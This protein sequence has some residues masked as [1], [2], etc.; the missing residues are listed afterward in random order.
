MGAGG[1]CQRLPDWIA[2]MRRVASE[3]P[4]TGACT[5]ATAM[6]LW[7]WTFDH[8]RR[9]RSEVNAADVHGESVPLTEALGWLLSSRAFVLEMA[10]GPYARGTGDAMDAALGDVCHAHVVRACGEVA[11]ICAELVFGARRHPAW[12]TD[13]DACYHAHDLDVVEDYVPGLASTARAYSDVIEADGSH[14]DKAGPCV[15]FDGVEEFVRLRSKLDG[16]LAG[17]HIARIRAAA[18][19]GGPR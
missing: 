4:G 11:R 16:C 15:R 18:A 2:T 6:E 5:V 7:A 8:V 14:P 10:Q 12:D 9:E 17:G 13:G 19:L 3:H 1:L